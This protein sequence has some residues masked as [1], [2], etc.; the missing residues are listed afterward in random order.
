MRSGARHEEIRDAREH[1]EGHLGP[2]GDLVAQVAELLVSALCSIAIQR[3]EA[4]RETV[5]AEGYFEP[6]ARQAFTRKL[7][8]EAREI[9]ELTRYPHPHVEE[10][11]VDTA[12]LDPEPRAPEC[13]VPRSEASHAA[14]RRPYTPI[15][16]HKACGWRLKTRILQAPRYSIRVL[17]ALTRWS[18]DLFAPAR[19]SATRAQ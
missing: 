19:E 10:A 3:G 7:L 12:D 17:P 6:P 9:R 2:G 13:R 1:R 5:D 14:H 15:R 16:E 8:D 4:E 11:M 18:G